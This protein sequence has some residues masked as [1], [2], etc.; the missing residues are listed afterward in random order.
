MNVNGIASSWT[1]PIFS[2]SLLSGISGPTGWSLSTG[3]TDIF[4]LGGGAGFMTWSYTGV[5]DPNSFALFS[6]QSAFGPA[7]APFQY[8]DLNG[9]TVNASGVLVPLSPLALAAGLQ[10]YISPIISPVPE[11]ET[12]ALLCA[13][14][15]FIYLA[16]RR[17]MFAA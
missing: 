16:K 11:P 3:T 8:I 2:D 15:I 13:G 6:F 12:W 1:M 17:R 9:N 5:V 4:G 14:L 10:P 7:T